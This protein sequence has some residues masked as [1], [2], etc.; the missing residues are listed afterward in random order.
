M[1]F[2]L[3]TESKENFFDM[4]CKTKKKKFYVAHPS[5]SRQHITDPPSHSSYRYFER[6]YWATLRLRYAAAA[7]TISIIVGEGVP[8]HRPHPASP[9]STSVAIFVTLFRDTPVF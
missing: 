4:Y 8:H 9:P 1:K 2:F 5:A 3:N 6:V 7:T